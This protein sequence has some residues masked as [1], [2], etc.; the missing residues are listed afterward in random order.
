MYL[1][2]IKS[3]DTLL[4]IHK[5]DYPMMIDQL[6][7][8]TCRVVFNRAGSVDIKINPSTLNEVYSNVTSNR[9]IEDIFEKKFFDS[10]RVGKLVLL[11]HFTQIIV[12]NPVSGWRSYNEANSL[13]AMTIL[14]STI[15]KSEESFINYECIDGDYSYYGNS[16]RTSNIGNSIEYANIFKGAMTRSD[17]NIRYD[18]HC[19]HADPGLISKTYIDKAELFEFKLRQMLI[20]PFTSLSPSQ[21]R[22]V[23]TVRGE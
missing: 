4:L 2:Y 3:D 16:I 18:L 20:D 15:K 7:E 12:Q 5:S 8:T 14:G 6:D 22:L 13:T 10:V 9:F 19:D 11:E 1:K 17:N 21:L 23:K